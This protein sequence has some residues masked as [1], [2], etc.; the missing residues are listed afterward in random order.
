MSVVVRHWQVTAAFLAC[1][2]ASLPWLVTS[3]PVAP[4]AVAGGCV[5]LLIAIHR[6]LLVCIGFVAF[7]LMR[8]HEAYPWLMPLQ[9]LLGLA[10]LTAIALFCN[11]LT[12]R[13]RIAWPAEIRLFIAFFSLVTI[14][15]VF[16]VSPGLSFA[17]WNDVFVKIGLMTLALAWLPR[18]EDDF[19][20]IARVIA[21]SGLLV[22]AVA[23]SNKLNGIDL[24][25]GTRVTVGLRIKSILSDPNDLAF[26]LLTTLSLSIALLTGG[27]GWTN[28][29][30][31]AVCVPAVLVA[32]VYT[33]SRGAV[34]GVLTVFAVY[35]LR[36]VR[37]R[38]VLVII[39]LA[40][41]TALYLAM[42][43][44]ERMSKVAS[45]QGLDASAAGRL[46]FWI[47]ALKA[48]AVRPLTGVGLA[49]FSWFNYLQTGQYMTTHNTWLQV[50]AE[51]GIPGLT[52][53][54]LM[55]ARAF[56][57]SLRAHRLLSAAEAR[58]PVQPVAY[59][60]V[61]AIAGY[62]TAGLFLS[63][64]FTWPIYVMIALAAAIGRYVDDNT[65]L[66]RGIPEGAPSNMVSYRG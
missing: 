29:F 21:V 31:G 22:A 27:T 52:L 64:G 45:P 41:A 26:L 49:N 13:I 35:G 40:G 36:F 24:V 12:G 34:L 6:P 55:V 61:A 7:S 44:S 30:I 3:S 39:C 46:E 5:A 28:R 20:L 56:R 15:S 18:T 1:A 50:L 11:A 59:G 66:R 4:L 9:P 60:L 57:S 65:Q 54:V 32:I 19:H 16:A 43:I 53:F 8:L 51:T 23:I 17:Y 38:T 63:Q 14:G 58:S 48:A 33:Q 47:T 25:E 42:G 2:A 62:C 37:S 10:V